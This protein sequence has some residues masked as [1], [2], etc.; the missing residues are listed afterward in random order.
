LKIPLIEY[1]ASASQALPILASFRLG[2]AL[3]IARR[4]IVGWAALLLLDDAVSLW[5]ALHHAE[6][7]WI[8]YIV[9]PLLVAAVLMGLSYWQ[10][11]VW[12][13]TLYRL[14]IPFF[15]L[16]SIVAVTLIE[17]TASHS[18]VT[19]PFKSLILFAASLAVV[20]SCAGRLEGSLIR[21]DWF[22][23]GIGL[24]L[25]Y[26]TSAA[27]DPI[28][29]I[30]VGEDLPTLVAVHTAGAWIDLAASLL[31]AGGMLCPVPPLRASSGRTSSAS[32]PSPSSLPR[33]AP[34]S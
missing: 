18:I 19:G 20:L 22:W 3:P 6:N 21:Q 24:A 5:Y 2:R 25:T 12:V 34:P 29:R 11:V 33:S 16:T 1:V 26:G 9:G 8:R 27:F 13:K 30:L 15:I 23:V 4:W 17:D 31:I 14:M 10:P 28:A 7:L 32:S